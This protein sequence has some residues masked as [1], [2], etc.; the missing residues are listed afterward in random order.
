MKTCNVCAFVFHFITVLLLEG[1][2]HSSFVISPR[3]QVPALHFYNSQYVKN[4]REN[5]Y[6]IHIDSLRNH[7][8][9]SR[10][11]LVSSI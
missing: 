5:N 9:K 7:M 8:L 2:L 1:L 6:V 11:G 10:N 4:G 3:K